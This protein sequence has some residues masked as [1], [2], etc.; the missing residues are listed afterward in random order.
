MLVIISVAMIL[1]DIRYSTFSQVRPY[2]TLLVTPIQV[3][4]N[5]P[6]K[7]LYWSSEHLA[8]REGLVA[9]NQAL[10][11]EIL[12]LRSRQQRLDS[13]QAENVRL[14][15]LLDASQRVDEKIVMAEVIGFDQNA[16]SH[17]LMIDKGFSSGAYVGQPVLD[18][19]GVLG[20]VVETAAYSSRVLLIADASHFIP[21]QLSR[22]G[23]RGILRGTGDL[24][25]M[26]LMSV[27]RSVDIKKGDILTTSGLDNRFPSGYPVG[28]VRS[29]K[30][31]QGKSYADVSVVPLAQLGRSRHV[32]LIDKSKAD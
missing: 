14:R 11:S 6:Q 29:V 17:R 23:L 20:Q 32:M 4:V 24:K 18:A 10:Q 7:L 21:V 15:E 2:L 8:S 28:V 19:T 3:V 1:A 16:Y 26:E 25:E 27:P 22:T 12:L 31:T 30:H 5:T 13:L 9:E